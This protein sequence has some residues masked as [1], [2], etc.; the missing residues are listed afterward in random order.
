MLLL[1]LLRPRPAGPLDWL[2]LTLWERHHLYRAF[3]YRLRR[4][5]AGKL[6]P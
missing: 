2:F 1:F 6:M 3:P 5:S 4:R